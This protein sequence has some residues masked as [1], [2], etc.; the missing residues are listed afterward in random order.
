MV[1]PSESRFS[2]NYPGDDC[3]FLRI[4]SEDMFM[5]VVWCFEIAQDVND[6]VGVKLRG[7][8]L[9]LDLGCGLPSGTRKVPQPT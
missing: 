5:Y 3:E 1:L 9:W 6:D 7:A 2:A 4:S 8:R